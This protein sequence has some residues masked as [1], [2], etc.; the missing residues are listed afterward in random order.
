MSDTQPPSDDALVRMLL[1]DVNVLSQTETPL[2]ERYG[3]PWRYR[4]VE[5]GSVSVFKRWQH[6]QDGRGAV[7]CNGCQ[8]VFD[9]VQDMKRD[10]EVTL[11]EV[12]R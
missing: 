5:C 10:Q 6:W 3:E 1:E 12:E 4:C 7:R 9:R 8:S 2:G 11:R